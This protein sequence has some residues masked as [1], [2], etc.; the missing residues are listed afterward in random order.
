MLQHWN[1]CV[2]RCG[3]VMFAAD[4]EAVM[5]DLQQ[6]FALLVQASAAVP[7]LQSLLHSHCLAL[8]LHSVA[9]AESALSGLKC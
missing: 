5:A 9:R 2:K 6:F 8:H 1:A 7:R 4:D 3:P